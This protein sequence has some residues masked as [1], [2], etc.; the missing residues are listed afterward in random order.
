M[1]FPRKDCTTSTPNLTPTLTHYL[2]KNIL[3]LYCWR[4]SHFVLRLGDR[5]FDLLTALSSVAHNSYTSTLFSV[6]NRFALR[7]PDA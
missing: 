2:K 7:E 6:D 4:V 5:I 1:T 3:L